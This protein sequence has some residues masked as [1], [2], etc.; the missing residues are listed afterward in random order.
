MDTIKRHTL[1]VLVDNE[2]GVLS[3]VTRLFSRKRYGLTIAGFLLFWLGMGRL[4]LDVLH[5][6]TFGAGTGV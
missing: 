4:M 3:Q 5:I 1:A 6:G 2:A